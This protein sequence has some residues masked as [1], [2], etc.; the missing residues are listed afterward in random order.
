MNDT[1]LF[2]TNLWYCAFTQGE[3]KRKNLVAKTIAGQRLVFGHSQS[4]DVFALNDMCPH[5]GM[6]LSYGNF[7]GKEIECCYHGWRFDTTGQC[8][9]IPSLVKSQRLDPTRIQ[10]PH[11]PCRIVQGQ[12]WVYLGQELTESV[13]QPIPEVPMSGAIK[14]KL[15]AKRQ[16]PC[17]IDHAVIGL[18][19]PAHGPFVHQSWWWRSSRSLHEKNKAF[20]PIPFGFKMMR[21]QP[22]KNS[23]A[24]KLLSS[25][26]STE[27]RF[28][29]PGVRIE[30][31]KI[32]KYHL[33]GLTTVTPI[34]E[35]QTEVTQSFYWDLPWLGLLKP[36][37]RHFMKTF[38]RQDYEAVCKQQEGL[39]GNPRLM[40]I[41]DAD[42]QAKW[43]FKL[44]KE[45]HQ[46]QLEAREF[47]NPVTAM[48][49]QWTS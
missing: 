4:G 37:L 49:L 16:F 44:K 11:F 17:N 36:L 21:H 43:Y 24:Y 9:C 1:P 23:G 29:L 27:I 39:Q 13:I 45:F 38:L 25:D 7:D 30:H 8:T 41:N 3:L 18:M 46:A 14:P 47:L 34:D 15:I 28:Q 33:C 26:I 5:R 31:I 10:V 40:L 42:M 20:A 12:V 48:E 35:Q 19:D 6:P 32:G 22:S 2:L